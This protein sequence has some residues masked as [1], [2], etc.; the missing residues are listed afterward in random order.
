MRG[1][2]AERNTGWYD[3]KIRRRM[4]RK[5]WDLRDSWSNLQN[6]NFLT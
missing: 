3:S 2:D 5:R 6:I 1:G 4:D